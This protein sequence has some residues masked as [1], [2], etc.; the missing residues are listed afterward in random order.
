MNEYALYKHIGK[1]VQSARLTH[2]LTQDDLAALVGLTRTSIVNLEAGRQRSPVHVLYLIAEKLD[3][4]IHDLLPEIEQVGE[5]VEVKLGA[6]KLIL[7]VAE[8]NELRRQ[9][10]RSGEEE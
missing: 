4:P 5:V 8:A 3:I 1:A 7:T 10:N 6:Q 9:L 2:D